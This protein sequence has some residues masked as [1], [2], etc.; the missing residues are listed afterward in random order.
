MT[1]LF[2]LFS[3]LCVIS[4]GEQDCSF[5]W[6]QITDRAEFEEQYELYKGDSN[7]DSERVGAFTVTSE[8]KVFY[9]GINMKTIVHEIDHA[10]CI[11]ENKNLELRELCHHTLD[12]LDQS[13]KST[14]TI[15]ETPTPP[16]RTEK[17]KF[18]E[19]M[20]SNKVFGQ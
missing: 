17:D 12:M 14:H 7:L 15:D 4:N 20:Y 8:R 13:E 2:F 1:P 19:L 16:E 5:E 10:K 6:T 11:I 9:F 3:T 18:Q